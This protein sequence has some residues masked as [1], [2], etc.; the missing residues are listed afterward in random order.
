MKNK[1]SFSPKK[2]TK[3]LLTPLN[4]RAKEVLVGRFGLVDVGERKTLE[5][6][7]RKYGITRERVR[8]IENFALKVI[9]KSEN[10]IQE[11]PVFEE[12]KTIMK[13][14]GTVV[15]E[16]DF[17]KDL[18]K[19]KL[20]QNHIHFYLVLHDDFKSSKEDDNFNKHWSIDQKV[21]D[22]VHSSLI[23]LHTSITDEEMIAENIL[24]D[25]FLKQMEELHDVYKS[26]EMLNKYLALSKAL[27]KNQMGE[28]GKKTSPN[29]KTR[30]IKD[31][32]YLIV[33]K[34]GQPMHFRDVAKE[35]LVEFGRK[36][37]TATCHNE[38]I[39]DSRFVLVGRG[40]YGLREW[41][42][43]GGIVRDV[44]V[45]VM[46][47]KGTPMTKNEIIELV[48]KE[49]VVKDNT[50]VVNLQNPKYFTKTDDGRYQVNAK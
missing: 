33:R 36:A 22:V 10:F 43:S 8:Q 19:D 5:S 13:Q 17:L 3:N 26:K 47:K 29:I 38:L 50:V 44:I 32:A 15:H 9:K 2:V 34:R 18:A 27:G 21:A 49:R 28:W 41:G 4:A 35:I 42:H 23:S 24:L 25:R 11:L 20:T 6:I 46:T 37:H 48:K 30:G 40:I 12:L 1:I 16:E 45:E 39:R 7:G 31:F 14:A